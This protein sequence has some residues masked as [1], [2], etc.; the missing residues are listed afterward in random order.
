LGPGVYL[1]VPRIDRRQ[2]PGTY[3]VVPPR[4]AGD[5]CRPQAVA[6]LIEVGRRQLAD[7]SGL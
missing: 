5:L 4:Y 3:W 2:P 7:A 1:G 6:A